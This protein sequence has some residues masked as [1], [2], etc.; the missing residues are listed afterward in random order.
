MPNWVFNNLHIEGSEEEIERVRE[1]LAKP[2]SYDIES[3][4]YNDETKTWER[5]LKKAEWKEPV[6]AFWNIVAPTDLE[7]YAKQPERSGVALNDPEWWAKT[8]AFSRTQNDWY[9]WN[10]NNWG[11]KWDVCGDA[12]IT[13]HSGTHIAYRFD[14]AWSPPVPALERLSEQYP[15]L[16]ITLDWEEEQGF[17]GEI[18]FKDGDIV[19]DDGYDSKC[20]DCDAINTLDYCDNGCGSICSSCHNLGEA[21]LECVLECEE[22]KQFAN[23]KYVPD[24]RMH[25]IEGKV[26]S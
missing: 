17:G 3:S 26:K 23:E 10:N 20:R 21:D 12:T 6:F 7:A 16:E 1:Q 18:V 5:V 14:T 4:E 13:D 19:S 15:N 24:Y 2:I 11:T 9:N 22:H 8:E 25:Q